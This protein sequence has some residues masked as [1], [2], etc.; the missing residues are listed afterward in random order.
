[1]AWS[2]R[3]GVEEVVVVGFVLVIVRFDDVDGVWEEKEV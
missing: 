1:M 2:L 3:R